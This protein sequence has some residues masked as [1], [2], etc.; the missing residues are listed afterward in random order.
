MSHDISIIS[1]AKNHKIT[2]EIKAVAEF[3]RME[4]E[5]IRRRVAAGKIVIPY[6]PIY[7]PKPLGIGKGLTVKV[8]ANI[9]TSC[10]YC[11][12]NEE[13]EKAKAAIDAGVH[14]LMNLSTGGGFGY[15]S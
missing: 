5:V 14:A 12:V 4:T 1:E 7:S 2:E 6:N 3:E 13:V 8:N 15:Y 10:E 9:G 11:D